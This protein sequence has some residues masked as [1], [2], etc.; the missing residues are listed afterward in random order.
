MLFSSLVPLAG[1]GGGGPRVCLWHPD[2][3]SMLML[4]FYYFKRLL[5]SFKGV[6]SPARV[7]VF[8]LKSILP[9]AGLLYKRFKMIIE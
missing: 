4:I 3:P 2:A 7:C 9:N 1:K 5:S 6:L 8:V